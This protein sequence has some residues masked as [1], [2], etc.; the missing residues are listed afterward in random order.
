MTLRI[1][2]YALLSDCNTGALIGRDGLVDW[3]SCLAT[4]A[5]PSETGAPRPCSPSLRAAPASSAGS[6]AGS[7][8]SATLTS[9]PEP[10]ASNSPPERRPAPRFCGGRSSSGRP[11]VRWLQPRRR[12]GRLIREGAHTGARPTPE[13]A[14]PCKS[15]L[16]PTAFES[17]CAGSTPAGAISPALAES[18]S[19]A[20]SLRSG[21]G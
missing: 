19:H 18:A 10:A 5:R 3:P 12:L 14:T 17:A 21:A 1:G 9:R 13:P 16:R 20:G 15:P 4:T 11:D 2:D 6:T 8:T 7:R